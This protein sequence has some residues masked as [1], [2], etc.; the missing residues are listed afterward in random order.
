MQP[1]MPDSKQQPEG[2]SRRSLRVGAR[3]TATR[4]LGFHWIAGRTKPRGDEQYSE[5]HERPE[6]RDLY[7]E[8]I[9]SITHFGGAQAAPRQSKLY[10]A[11][12]STGG[13]DSSGPRGQGR[14]GHRP[15][16]YRQNTQ[17]P[18]SHHREAAES[19]GQSARCADPPP[20]PGTRH[21]GAT[22]LRAADQFSHRP[23]RRWYGRRSA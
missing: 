17:L 18:Y 16:R 22:G 11:H 7:F 5:S 20:D 21:A 19:P 3:N 10:Y 15:D 13:S 14:P 6:A 2:R 23:G 8:R 9:F 12:P 4:Q 1:T